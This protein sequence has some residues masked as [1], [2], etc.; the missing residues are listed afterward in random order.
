MS[1][2]GPCGRPLPPLA[3]N[4][5]PSGRIP[6][7][8]APANARATYLLLDDDRRAARRLN[9]GARRAAEL[10]RVDGELLGE[11]ALGEDLDRH[12]LASA[13][14]LGLQRLEGHLVAGF[15]AALEVL[16]VDRLGM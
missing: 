2:H 10:V 3:R 5:G 6:H 7:P 9:G 15:E 4:V 11:R 16:E 13:Q 1:A 12:V 14:A 8:R